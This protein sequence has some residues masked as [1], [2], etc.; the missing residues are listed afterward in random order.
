MQEAEKINIDVG[1]RARMPQIDNALN[2]FPTLRVMELRSIGDLLF[3]A[4]VTVI[5]CLLCPLRLM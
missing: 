5:L 3:T 2:Q 1:R 4:P